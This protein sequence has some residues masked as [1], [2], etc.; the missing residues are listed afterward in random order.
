MRKE[1]A[2]RT[3]WGWTSL[4]ACWIFANC[5]LRASAPHEVIV[6]TGHTGETEFEEPI[7]KTA[8]KWMEAGK[9]AG[10]STVW[11]GEKT[12]AGENRVAGPV[13]DALKKRLDALEPVSSEPLWLV[14]I[15]HGNAQGRAPKFAL[16][17]PDLS[18]EDLAKWLERLRRPVVLVAGFA[19]SGA[20]VKPLSGKERVIV[21]GTRSG[22]EENWVR[23]SA[24]FAE[25]ISGGKADWDGDGQV[26]VFEAWLHAAHAVDR[27]YKESGR[28][29][30]E[31]AVLEDSGDGK[32]I[33]R[34]SF[35]APDSSKASKKSVPIPKIS[36]GALARQWCLLASPIEGA[37]SPEQ[38]ERRQQLEARLG[39]LRDSKSTRPVDEYWGEVEKV[40]LELEAVYRPAR[41]TSGAPSAGR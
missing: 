36:D 31:H 38:R 28:M 24:Y 18:A 20:F 1:G 5:T 35:D 37:L 27:F 12:S 33:G 22:D 14:L 10:H 3:R 39:A 30:T 16:E 25:A 19:G 6:V 17:G 41:E 40:L 23:F 7:F 13:L 11:L 34:E 9:R 8:E 26:S 21:A 32:A 2:R 15:G 4:L 29:V